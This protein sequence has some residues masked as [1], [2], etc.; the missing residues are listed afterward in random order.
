MHRTIIHGAFRWLGP[1]SRP[2]ERVVAGATD[3]A[4]GLVSAGIR[5]AGELGAAVTERAA[6]VGGQ[7]DEVV[8]SRARLRAQAIAHGVAAEHVVTSAPELD[9]DVTLVQ[10]RR[11]VAADPASLETA[12]PD[13][14]GQL[15]V[16][17]HGLVHSEDAWTEAAPGGATIPELA[18]RQ[19]WTPVAVRYG[20]GRPVGRNGADLARLLDDTVAA[21]PVPVTRIVIVSHS[22]GGLLTR[23]AI[24]TAR[25]DERSWPGLVSDGVYIGT[26]HLGSWLEKFANVTTWTLRHSSS[27]SAPIGTLLDGRSQ[28]IKDLRFGTLSE[29]DWRDVEIDG[30]LTGRRDALTWDAGMRHHIVAGR[31]RDSHRHP[32]TAALGDGLVR[33]GAAAGRGLT[34]QMAGDVRI[35]PITA[36]HTALGRH[37]ETLRLVRDVLTTD[38][39]C[40][41]G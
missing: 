40:P 19:G 11:P 28:G 12:F 29:N 32:L 34:R 26:P 17:L 20:S 23:A 16:L 3:V 18:A 9:I 38:V 31:L 36:A 30:L 33:T 21:W 7:D 8:P 39:R 35:V 13:A 1:P 4:Y 2:V 41:P 24:A 14:T 6:R 15:V 5:G 25:E 37:P 10:A 22:M 27:R